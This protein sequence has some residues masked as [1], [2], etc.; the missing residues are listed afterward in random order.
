MTAPA[1]DTSVAAQIWGDLFEV[2]VKR[3]S[4]GFLATAGAVP[5]DAI[6]DWVQVPVEQLHNYLYAS[7]DIIDPGEQARHSSTLAHLLVQGYGLGWTALRQAFRQLGTD[8]INIRALH[9]PLLL[10]GRREQGRRT[11]DPT[12]AAADFWRALRLEGRPDPGWAAQGEPANADLLLWLEKES[13]GEQHILALEFSANAPATAEDFSESLPHLWELL[14]HAR[15]IENRGVFTRVGA[16]LTDEQFVFNKRLFGN[17]SAF[18][19]RDKPFFKLCQAASYATQFLTLMTRRGT[20]VPNATAHAIAIT[21]SGVESVRASAVDSNHP[22]WKLMLALGEAYRE[23]EKLDAENPSALNDEIRMARTN[24][25]QGLPSSFRQVVTEALETSNP[26]SGFEVHLCEEVTGM[27]NP[28][29]PADVAT[30]LAGIEESSAIGD[31]LG[32]EQPGE[33]LRELVCPAEETS[34]TL[35]QVHA[36]TTAAAIA[37]ARP[38]RITVIGAEGCPGIGKTTAVMDALRTSE[39]GFLW[40]YASPRLVIN[41][42]VTSRMARNDGRSTETL[43]MTTNARLIS[44]AGPWWRFE[45]PHDRRRVE[46]AVVVDG[47]PGIRNLSGST[48]LVTPEQGTEIEARFSGTPMRKSTLDEETDRLT[49]EFLPGVLETLARTARDVLR[50]NP[51]VH[52]LLLAT[53]IQGFRNLL[54]ADASRQARDTVE[55]LSELFGTRASEPGGDI[56]RA[57]FAERISTIVVMVDEIAGDGAGGPFVHALARWLSQEFLDPF[58]GPEGSPFRVVLVLADASL[59]NA[60][61]LGSYLEHEQDA[62][63]KVLISPSQAAQPFRVQ[64]GTVRLNARR[65]PVLHVMADGYFAS[66]LKIDYRL[67]LARVQRGSSLEA[68]SISARKVI[69]DQESQRILRRAVESV[70]EAV[71]K[72]APGQQVIFYAQDKLLLRAVCDGLL[73]PAQLGNPGFAP[74]QTYDV[75]FDEEQIAILDAAIPPDERLKLVQPAVR[76]TKRVFLMTSS[77]ARGVS[78]PLVT[79]IVA[80]VPRFSIES[81]FMELA[82]L[83]YRGRGQ[84]HDPRSGEPIDGDMLDRRI[85]LVMHDF[86]LSDDDVDPRQWLRRTLDMLSA[87][88]LLRATLLTRMTGDSGIPGQR[89]AI[90]PVG[91]I[92]TDDASDGLANAVGVFLHESDVFLYRNPDVAQGLIRKAREGVFAFFESYRR[93]GR[94]DAGQSSITQHHMLRALI[95]RITARLGPL[96]DPSEVAVLPDNVYAVGPVWMESWAP[97]PSEESFRIRALLQGDRTRLELLRRQLRQIGGTWRTFP[98]QLTLA[99]RDLVRI[100]D[101]PE[102]LADRNFSATRKSEMVKRWVCVP[103]DYTS[104]CFVE[105]QHGRIPRAPDSDEHALWRDGMLRLVTASATATS[106]EP[107]I[108]RYR[109]IPFLVVTT[110]G[111]P[112]G[113][114]RAFDSRY[115]MASTELNLLNTLLFVAD[116]EGADV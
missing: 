43:T 88:V 22:R 108:P 115:F 95:G 65:L 13:G 81:G 84:A 113:L 75:T 12:R 2:A 64:A 15:R 66:S 28:A 49:R 78:F 92:G 91:R 80:M 111:D 101:R 17:L 71:A 63:E 94:L 1:A 76:D 8:D 97:I 87:L 77:G 69:L 5:S 73:H 31:M 99:A 98:Q 30:L 114:S 3:G 56:E 68:Q 19:T 57:G 103:L 110:P 21:N 85:V 37:A 60:D 24:V 10:P 70:F 59:A 104:F 26:S 109:D 62:P 100:L 55:R 23:F 4:L 106:W 50:L 51:S 93:I 35:R 58:D 11:I 25:V 79:T 54:H 102:E 82:Q 42:D 96:F 90:V 29:R 33:Y 6:K 44:G 9:C 32:A 36:K 39:G 27:V 52:R 61:V 38:G 105:G 47:V 72:V 18:T 67:Q 86:L 83:V 107:I 14:A 16:T 48:L 112:T 46:A 40:L 34:I 53:S 89:A 74:I 7:L 45:H 20:P 41:G 116:T